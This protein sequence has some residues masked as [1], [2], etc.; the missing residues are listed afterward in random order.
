MPAYI[1]EAY[2]Y[3]YRTPARSELN[4]I[5]GFGVCAQARAHLGDVAEQFTPP[6]LVICAGVGRV[7]VFADD[8]ALVDKCFESAAL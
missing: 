5:G 4:F 2:L 8:V 6:K 1:C 7:Y 3:D